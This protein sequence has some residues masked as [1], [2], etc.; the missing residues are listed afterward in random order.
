[1]MFSHKFNHSSDNLL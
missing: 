1:M